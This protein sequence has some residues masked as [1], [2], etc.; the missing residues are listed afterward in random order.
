[1]KK[2]K[3]LGYEHVTIDGK[4]YD[5]LF[6]MKFWAILEERG[7]PASKV[8]QSIIGNDGVNKQL[9]CLAEVISSGNEN[10][11]ISSDQL[12]DPISTEKVQAAFRTKIK[13]KSIW[14]RLVS[15]RTHD[16]I[17]PSISKDDMERLATTLFTSSEP[18][19][20]MGEKLGKSVLDEVGKQ[21]EAKN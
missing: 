18:G 10:F 5:L 6:T 9:A 12:D 11:L 20:A 8:I 7:W 14:G 3:E 17:P 13:K 15:F 21:K 4:R 19:K 16:L 1:M 2:I